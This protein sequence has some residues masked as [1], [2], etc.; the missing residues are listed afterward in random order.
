MSVKPTSSLDEIAE[1][2]IGKC[3]FDPADL[4]ALEALFDSDSVI[5]QHKAEL[6]FKINLAVHDGSVNCQQWHRLFSRAISRYVI[7]DLNSPGEIAEC[8]S[9]WLHSQMREDRPLS[10]AEIEMLRELQS[11]STHSCEQMKSLY[12]RA[13]RVEQFSASPKADSNQ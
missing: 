11:N 12:D 3:K 9:N 10:G 5:D 2:I 8:E 4:A 1:R 7:F 6:L 13:K